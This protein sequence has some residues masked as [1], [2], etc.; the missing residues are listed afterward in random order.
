VREDDD[1]VVVA[2]LVDPGRGLIAAGDPRRGATAKLPELIV[3]EPPGRAPA[4]AS[5]APAFLYN[6]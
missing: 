3:I 4:R 5:T 6:H 2:P 1:V